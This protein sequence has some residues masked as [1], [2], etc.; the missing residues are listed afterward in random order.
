MCPDDSNGIYNVP[1]GTIV[2]SGDTVLPS[3]HNPWANDSATAISNRYSK[4]GRAPLT[5]NMNVNGFLLRNLGAPTANADAATKQYVDN[6][7]PNNVYSLVSTN[8]AVT[9]SDKGKWYRTVTSGITFTPDSASTL[10]ANNFFRIKNDSSGFVFVDP[11]GAETIN[12]SATL[13]IPSGQEVFVI[14][15]GM[16]LFATIYSSPQQGPQLQGYVYG[17]L[18]TTNS[19]TPATNIDIASGAAASSASPYYL[20][21]LAASI[22]KN[23]SASWSVGSGS[24]SLDT[25]FIANSTYYGFLIQR[26]DTGVVDVLTSLSHTNPTL[27]ANYDRRSPAIFTFTREGGVNGYPAMLGNSGEL[28]MMHVRDQRAS[29]VAGGSSISGTQVRTLNTVVVNGIPGASLASNQ[30]S[31]PAGTYDIDASV[32]AY[33]IG[34]GHK[35]W[36]RTSTGTIL[37]VGSSEGLPAT[38]NVSNRSLLKGRFTLSSSGVVEIAHYTGAVQGTTGLGFPSSSGQAEVYTD[39]VFRKVS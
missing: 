8:T 36:L 19:G 20:I 31:L 1:N 7:V 14:S 15:D 22:T 24:G 27:P 13:L 10:G 17:L 29:G 11:S 5:G 4:D 16:N 26:S 2:N 34:A 12:G 9:V 23:T 18:A 35:A 3:Q 33:N 30:I 6:A 21:Q 37:V 28:S 39:A 25:G 32:S 38:G